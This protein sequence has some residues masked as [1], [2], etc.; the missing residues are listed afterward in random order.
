MIVNSADTSGYLTVNTYSLAS[1]NYSGQVYMILPALSVKTRCSFNVKNFPFDKQMCSINLTSWGQG[2]NRVLY[3]EDKS[4]V[5]DSSEY[6]EHPLWALNGTDLAT[7]SAA[8]R[9][10]F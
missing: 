1:V 9:S 3:T 6:S 4:L 10:P 2:I 5:V 7:F 8:D